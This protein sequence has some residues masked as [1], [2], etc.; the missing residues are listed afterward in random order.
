[1]SRRALVQENFGTIRQDMTSSISRVL[2]LDI[3]M[4]AQDGKR[5]IGVLSLLWLGT[6]AAAVSGADAPGATLATADTILRVEARQNRVALVSLKASPTGWDWIA[7][8]NNSTPEA[9]A[10]YLLPFITSA[11]VGGHA[12]TLAWRFVGSS[13]LEG[14]P[15][16]YVLTFVCPDPPLELRS[17]WQAWPGPGPIEHRLTI[18]NKGSAP[19]QLPLQTSLTLE[20]HAPTDHALENWW[21][22]KGANTPTPNGTHHN[23]VQ[24]DFTAAL[25]S[26]PYAREEAQARDAIPWTAA[27][28]VE[29]RQ[30]W[31]AGVEFSGRVRLALRGLPPR[32]STDQAVGVGLRAD[33]GLDP[34]EDAPSPYRTRLAPGETFEAPTVFLGCY[35]GDVD[36]GSNRLHRWVE[37]HLRPPLPDARCPLLVSNSWGSGMA[38]DAALAQKMIAAAADLGLEVFHLDAGWYRRVGDWQPDPMKFPKGVAAIADEAH[39]KGLKFGLW[40]GWTQGGDRVD[41]TGKQALLSVFDPQMRPWFSHD[42]PRSWKPDDFTGAPVCLGDPQAVVWCLKKLRGILHDDHLDLLA[43]DQRI[44]VDDCDRTDHLHTYAP[45]DIAYRAARGY[46]QVYDALRAENPG[47]LFEDCVNGGHTV[48]YGIVQ[49]THYV[50]ITD[51]YDPLS[52]RRAFYDASYALPPS[53]CECY[54]SNNPGPSL[55][56]FK[57]ML[58]SGMMGWCTLMCDT[59]L[60]SQPQRDTAKAEFAFYKSWLRPLIAHGNLY[61]VSERPDGERWDGMQYFDPAT[62]QGVLFAFRGTTMLD[63]HLFRLKGL[64][65]AARYEL[66]FEDGTAAPVVRSGED[67]M[68]NGLLVH[69]AEPQSSE[70]IRLLLQP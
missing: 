23:V 13:V 51:T 57:A 22:E 45:T 56:S 2:T 32:H 55:A 44:I 39:S 19:I 59:S 63:S 70:L 16:R 46:Y 26:L 30:G 24:A 69:L 61:H 38:V 20:T 58:R 52:N 37:T 64:D 50:C 48:D 54:V 27:Q 33:I 47:L 29:G 3:L 11:E 15:R 6:L 17:I 40:I 35:T 43:Q 66:T 65:P 8:P 41:E 21:V 18:T 4:E 42:Y 25:L 10:P 60:W 5:W 53:M 62:G 28:D 9:D 34:Q 14:A 49:R 68:R 31:Y 36:D 67:L 1:M 7:A 12:V